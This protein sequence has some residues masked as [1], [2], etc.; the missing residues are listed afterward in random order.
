MSQW[1]FVGFCCVIPFNTITRFIMIICMVGDILW[2][3]SAIWH[4]QNI[5]PTWHTVL[6]VDNICMFANGGGGGGV[7]MVFGM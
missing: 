5:F 3:D 1:S 2:L 6:V 7:V 4:C